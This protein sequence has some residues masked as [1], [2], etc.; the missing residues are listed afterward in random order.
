MINYRFKDDEIFQML[1]FVKRYH[2][3]P[4]KGSRGRTNQGSRAFGGELDDFLIKNLTE[5]AAC[6]I[7]QA[8]SPN[9]HKE[10]SPDF[11][12][13][14]NREVTQ[15]RDPD[16]T[17]VFEKKTGITRKPNVRVEVKKTAA[18]E[19]WFNA[20]EEQIEEYLENDTKGYMVYVSLDF[21]DEKEKKS[22]DITG[23]ILKKVVDHKRFDLSEFSDIEDLEAKI[24]FAFSYKDLKEKG[25]YFPAG[26]IM[27]PS[28]FSEYKGTDFSK[29]PEKLISNFKLIRSYKGKSEIS[30]KASNKILGKPNIDLFKTWD[31]KGDFSIYRKV[32]TGN[33]YI[34][35]NTEST[36]ENKNLGT[37]ILEPN[38]PYKFFL[39]NKLGTR[40]GRE[41]LKNN[42]EY[43]FSRRKLENLQAN[44]KNFSVE[45]V[46]QE[47][48]RMI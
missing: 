15:K 35:P 14:T 25:L 38:K 21:K 34:F 8:L 17:E 2:L 6:K 42:N 7:I 37:Y 46:C 33:E 36:L 31:T 23:S 29:D 43:S 12:V 9:T 47:I 16:I 44:S 4:S 13:Y 26:L 45:S 5:V 28:T 22:R 11:N 3:E 48:A 27:P 19:D 24:D 40:G 32:K 30:M 10:L 18:N 20:R 41:L 1:D 39:E